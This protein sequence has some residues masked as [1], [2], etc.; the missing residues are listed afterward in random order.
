MQP[1]RVVLE[2]A[3][4]AI[5]AAATAAAYAPLVIAAG[6]L[7]TPD[8]PRKIH[9]AP[10]PTAGGLAIGLGFALALAA[11][12]LWPRG[13]WQEALTAGGVWKAGLI[14]AFSYLAFA[15]GLADDYKALSAR[16]KMGFMIALALALSVFATRAESLPLYGPHVLTLYWPLAVIGSALWVFGLMNATNFM[17]GANGL[18]IGCTTISLVGVAILAEMGGAQDAAVLATAGA[19]AMLGFLVWNWPH[20]KIFAGDAGSLFAGVLAAGAALLLVEQGGV[21]PFSVAILFFPVLADTLLTFVWRV[22]RR[23]NL[24]NG[25]SDHF[26]QVAT[27]RGWTRDQVTLAYWLATAVCVLLA[28]FAVSM[29]QAAL[30]ADNDRAVL[31][32]IATS[33]G[34]ITLLCLAVAASA[35]SIY[36]R[37]AETPS[38]GAGDDEIGEVR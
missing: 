17:D 29:R 2:L 34:K 21:S 28:I 14:V 24:L 9:D 32:V 26:Y 12:A 8:R 30:A 19:G 11:L 18:A 5:V 1:E 7:D 22:Q 37:R 15:M 31:T 27:R 20:G 4:A 6:L 23:E 25:H 33:T 38:V 36:V 13:A 3:V 35:V 10:T 16:M